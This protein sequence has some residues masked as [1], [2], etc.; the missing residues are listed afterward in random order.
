MPRM[1]LHIV[2]TCTKRKTL[3]VSSGLCLQQVSGCDVSTRADEWVRRISSVRKPDVPH[4]PAERLYCGDHWQIARSLTATAEASGFHPTLWVISTGYGLIPAD[5]PIAAYSATF[6]PSHE[7]TVGTTA[8]D[9]RTWWQRLAKWEGPTQA[10]RLLSDVAQLDSEAALLVVASE[11]YLAAVATDLADAADR[12]LDRD[13]LIVISAGTRSRGWL[14]RHLV[15]LDARMQAVLGGA[16]RTLNVRMARRVLV[17]AT[18]G[19]FRASS[20]LAEYGKLLEGRPPLAAPPRRK[21]TDVD[22]SRFV[23]DS[24]VTDPRGNATGLLRAFRSL[25]RACEQWRFKRLF[26]GVSA[27]LRQGVQSSRG[28]EQ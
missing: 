13:R 15:P 21:A 18:P 26:D 23:A 11:R 10:P 9:F 12:L 7:D 25:G 5:V 17:D 1:R 19:R 2:V 20:L 6:S 16:R 27:G 4:V 28:G 8:G 3:P 24:L 22:V 14:T